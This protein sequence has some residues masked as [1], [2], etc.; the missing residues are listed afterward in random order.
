MSKMNYKYKTNKNIHVLEYIF[1]VQMFIKERS[2]IAWGTTFCTNVHQTEEWHPL[3]C[4]ALEC[5]AQ[6]SV[7]RGF[8]VCGLTACVCVSYS[9]VIPRSVSFGPTFARLVPNPSL[10]WPAL[11]AESRLSHPACVRVK[12]SIEG[13]YSSPVVPFDPVC[14]RSSVFFRH[15]VCGYPS[16]LACHRPMWLLVLVCT[17]A[18]CSSAVQLA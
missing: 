10:I 9:R 13:F 16:Y 4:N 8:S 18:L 5:G 6:A 2:D 17:E 14:A 1:F 12:T 11:V 7:H 3:G 15:P